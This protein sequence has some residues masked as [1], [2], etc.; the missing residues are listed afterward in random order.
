MNAIGEADF[1][2]HVNKLDE[3][4]LSVDKEARPVGA[5]VGHA[6][7]DEHGLHH[8]LVHQVVK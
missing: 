2:S 3:A 5:I 4:N 8:H 7:K 1:I 6:A